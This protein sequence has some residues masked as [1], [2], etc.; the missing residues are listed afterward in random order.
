MRQALERTATVATT[1]R[2]KDKAY[3]KVAKVGALW[4]SSGETIGQ[5]IAIPTAIIMARLLSPQDFGIAAA[6]TFFIQLAKKV[7]GLGLNTAIVRM[8]DLRP[9]H[10]SSVFVVNMGVSLV[11]WAALMLAAPWFSVFFDEP[12][13]TGALR[14]AATVF[15]ANFLGT[16]EFA[17]LQRQMR[18]KAVAI[19]EWVGPSLFLVISVSM[20]MTGWG[21]WSLIWSQVVANIGVTCAKV[22]FGR[23]RPSLACT[24]QGLADTVP[25]GLAIYGKRLLTFGSQNLDSFIVGGLFGVTWLGFYDKAYNTTD[26]LVSK[27]SLG[28]GV[29]FRIFAILQEERDRFVRAYSKVILTATIVALPVFAGLIVA[30][31]EFTVVVFGEKWLPSV[32]PFQLL[33]AAGALRVVSSYATAAV[34]ASGLVWSEMW[35]SAMSLVL[36]VGFVLLLRGWGIEGT[37]LA[38]L[39]ASLISASVLQSLVRQVTGLTWR[40]LLVPVVPGTLA[41]IGTALVVGG[42]TVA[43]RSFVP[44]GAPWHT[45]LAQTVSG[46]LFWLTFTLFVRFQALQGVV[47]EVLA[48]LVPAVV[49]RRVDWFRRRA[50]GA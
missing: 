40:E 12:R 4:A 7:G 48:D 3:G 26:K 17:L 42:V 32:V 18:F 21:Y 23:W 19:I 30:G 25:F 39:L 27:L 33:C 13:V 22:Y 8:R 45:L 31:R 43:M 44:S 2:A 5:L 36:I 1:P 9:D 28:P 15:L 6:S 20:A 14:V 41:A 11:S 29:M 34:Q 38:V 24:R 35:R 47:D 37:A 46:G 50:S 49:R 16:V 10:L